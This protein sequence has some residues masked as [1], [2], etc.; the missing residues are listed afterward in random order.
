MS[1]STDLIIARADLDK[2]AKENLMPLLE[3]EP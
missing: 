1:V 3:T 2:V